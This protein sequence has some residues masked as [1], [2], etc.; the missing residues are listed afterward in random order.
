MTLVRLRLKGLNQ[1]TKRRRDGSSV[2]YW[3]AWKGGPSLP[4]K[5]GSPEFVAA[6][7]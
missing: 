1:V 2:T 3:Y 5:P 6:Y 4:G 7:N